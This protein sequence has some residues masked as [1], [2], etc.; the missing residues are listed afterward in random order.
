[1]V[2]FRQVGSYAELVAA[3]EVREVRHFVVIILIVVCALVSAILAYDAGY[4]AADATRQDGYIAG[5]MDA[6][7]GYWLPEAR[8]VYEIREA[9]ELLEWAIEQAEIRRRI[10]EREDMLKAPPGAW[11]TEQ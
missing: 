3:L 5:Q 7:H 4:W 11:S 2:V 1:M 6:A 9:R 10:M 8:E